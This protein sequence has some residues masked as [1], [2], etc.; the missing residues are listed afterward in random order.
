MSRSFGYLDSAEIG[1]LAQ[2]YLGVDQSFDEDSFKFL[3]VSKTDL[4]R[5]RGGVFDYRVN[6]RTFEAAHL[7]F[8]LID[9]ATRRTAGNASLFILGRR[10]FKCLRFWRRA[11]GNRGQVALEK[12][13]LWD[14]PCL[15]EVRRI[16]MHGYVESPFI[17][18]RLTDSISYVSAVHRYARFV[19]RL[20]ELCRQ[21]T[22]PMLFEPTGQL[23]LER[24][25]R[26]R[27]QLHVSDFTEEEY[28][29][30]GLTRSHSIG[31]EKMA[32]LLGLDELANVFNE[33]TLGKVFFSLP[34]KRTGR[35]GACS[36]AP[37]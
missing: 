22:V 37:G 18:L 16:L 25:R 17:G 9:C 5:L 33:R 14:L 35:S 24:S 28:A 27:T 6:E 12:V 36:K 21:R 10:H 34:R 20:A 2:A 1:R 11:G 23:A 15:L 29:R 13:T 3:S 7:S 30:I 8:V 31:A 26:A 4:R 32:R 19:I